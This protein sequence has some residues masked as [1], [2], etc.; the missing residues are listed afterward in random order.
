MTSFLIVFLALTQIPILFIYA[1][2]LTCKLTS[3][4]YLRKNPEWVTSHPDFKTHKI[5]NRIFLG[6]SYVLST[7]TLVAIIYYGFINPAPRLHL[8]LLAFPVVVSVIGILLYQGVFHL[9][10][11]KKLPVPKV[12]KASLIDRRLSSYIPM[13]TVYL[14]YGLLAA[15]FAIYA[16]ALLSETI[17]SELAI[18]RL[19]GLSG[20]VILGGFVLLQALRRKHVDSELFFG[21]IGRNIEVIATIVLLYFS[22]F[23]GV[24]LILADFFSIFLFADASFFIVMSLVIQGFYIITAL[25]PR[26]KAKL[27]EY[28]QNFV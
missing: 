7:A 5:Y 13:W 15:V 24:A 10:M 14:V 8:Q 20:I 9:A 22:V 26:I 28:S 16:W 18:R 21:S 4:N 23:L 25:N 27:Q 6:F 2:G 11:K 3:Y 19:T 12:R 1:A 17:V